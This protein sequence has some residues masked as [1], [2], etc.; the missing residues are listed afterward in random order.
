MNRRA[1]IPYSDA[2]MAWLEANRMMIISDYHRA[3]IALFCREDVSAGHLHALRKRKGWKIGP[4]AGRTKGRRLR[5]SDAEIAWLSANRA[6]LLADYH[7]S[8]VAVFGRD[9]VTPEKLHSL[10]KREGFQT[11]RSG[12]FEKGRPSPMK[13]RRCPPGEGGRHP[14]AIAAQ[15]KKGHVPHTHKGAGHESIGEEGYAWI[16]VDEKNP[17][18]GAATRRVQKHRWLWEKANGPV[19]EGHVLKCLDGDRS[20]ADLANWEAIPIGMLPRL[21]GKSGRNYDAAP[22]ELK[23]AIMAVAKLEHAARRRGRRSP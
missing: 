2:E 12:R 18:T 10:R 23:P 16:I 11:G 14:N 1:P 20:N 15:F 9:D 19:P 21:N 3:F 5:Y 8:F 22:D 6:L 4:Q 13:G 17:W 7:R